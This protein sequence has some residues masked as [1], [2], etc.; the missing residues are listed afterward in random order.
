MCFDEKHYKQLKKY[1]ITGQ[2][3]LGLK[4]ALSDFLLTPI[5]LL[6]LNKNI[7]LSNI[8]FLTDEQDIF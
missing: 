2:N 7:E 4:N 1:G 6:H 8:A 3:A 5:D